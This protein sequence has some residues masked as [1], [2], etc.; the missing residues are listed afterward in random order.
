MDSKIKNV[1]VG[2]GFSGVTMA[3]KLA[4]ELKEEVL[5]I[6]AKDHIGGN[7]Y[8]YYDKNGICIHK[9][10]A[11]IF[12]TNSESVW[13]Y[14]SQYTKWHPYMHEVKGMVD[15]QKVPIP[16]NL[17]SIEKLFPRSMAE[18]L[19]KKLIENFGFN[20]KI[21]ILRLRESNDK[22]LAF[23]ADYIYEKVFLDYTLKQWGV[24]P[25]DLDPAITGRVSVYVA[26]DNRYFQDKYQGIPRAGY[27]ALI[28]AMLS[29]PLI[30]VQLGTSFKDVQASIQY[31]RLF[32]TG[33]IDEYFDYKFGELP[34]RSLKFDFVEY[35]QE[36]FQENAVVNYPCNYKFTR[37]VEY[38]YF[39]NDRSNNTVV[40]FEYPEAFKRGENERY[41]PVSN[42]ANQELYNKYINEAAQLKN[43]YFCG[44]LG[45]YRYYDMDK[46]VS[47]ALELFEE[48]KRQA[49]KADLINFK[50]LKR[51]D[52]AA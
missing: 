3:N 19:E 24:K 23:L 34:Y 2:C 1:V 10:G 47:R 9:Y 52:K 29:S 32:Y 33:P 20:K 43:V 48:V 39:L 35:N 51:Y 49:H 27:A 45:D 17:N 28:N 42:E 38:K 26:K 12:H 7:S 14:L 30:K 36:C 46:A 15:G 5:I 6:D 41:Y 4:N 44:R 8:D 13:D 37:I 50:G 22:D 25:E 18:K 40:S 21:S 31:E 16:F 11:H